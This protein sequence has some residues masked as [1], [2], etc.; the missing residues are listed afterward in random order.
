MSALGISSTEPSGSITRDRT[1]E[2]QLQSTEH[3]T[4]F[5][6]PQFCCMFH[7]NTIPVSTNLTMVSGR[8]S[9]PET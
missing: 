6:C 8:V 2:I 4:K 3:L 9:S 5:T 7:T 1:P